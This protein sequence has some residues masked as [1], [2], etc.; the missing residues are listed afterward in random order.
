[1]SLFRRKTNPA[2]EG[3]SL[4]DAL[5]G[6][7]PLTDWIGDATGEPWVRFADAAA[8]L[9][10]SDNDGA[11]RALLSITT[12]PGLEP[13]HYLEAWHALRTL[14]HAPPAEIAKQLLGV[15]LEVSLP[16]GL[17]VLAVYPDH[18]ARYLNAGGGAAI[19]EHPSASLDPLIDQLLSAGREIVS[20]IGV[21]AGDR[22]GPPPKGHAR[23]TL[24]TPSGPHFGEGPLT[25]LQGDALAGPVIKTGM[26]IVGRLTQLIAAG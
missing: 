26:A 25:A 10:R 6:D 9:A 22:P 17:D 21:W 23:I 20:R 1:M 24:L 3:P 16:N 5:F 8:R 11:K 4:Q 18:T 14:G 15:V 7:R 13:R 12:T 19:W 2:P